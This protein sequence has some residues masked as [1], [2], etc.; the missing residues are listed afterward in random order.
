MNTEFTADFFKNR[1]RLCLV[2]ERCR[3]GNSVNSGFEYSWNICCLNASYGDNG[4]ADS[5]IPHFFH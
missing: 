5:G 2:G 4:S 1:S 3:D